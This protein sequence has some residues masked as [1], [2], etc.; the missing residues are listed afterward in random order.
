MAPAGGSSASSVVSIGRQQRATG[1]SGAGILALHSPLMRRST[2]SRHLGASLRLPGRSRGA[3]ATKGEAE[4]KWWLEVWEPVLRDGGFS[5]GDALDL[6]DDSAPAP[7]YEGRRWQQAR[8]EVTRVLREAAIEDEH[9]FAGKVVVDIGSGP[10]GFPDACPA[11]VS[12]GVDPLAERYASSGLLLDS[13]ALYL[14]TGA[15]DIPLVSATVDVVVARNCLDHVDDPDT[16]LSEVQRILR[17][18]GTLIL[19]FDVEHAPTATE[20][21]R[22]TTAGVKRMLGAFEIAHEDE[23]NGGH[24]EDGHAVVLVARRRLAST[25]PTTT[26]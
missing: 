10:L 8:A 24:G 21:H 25:T 26:P 16:A 3:A 13:D 20:P 18:G 19:N 9:F 11:R 5:P 17:P 23:W 14:S 12:I 7:S 2:I 1:I 4:L 15:E 22:L 6:I